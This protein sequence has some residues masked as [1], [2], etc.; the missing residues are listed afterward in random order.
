MTD[1]IKPLDEKGESFIKD[2]YHFKEML[3]GVE[4]EE[5]DIIGSLDIVGMFPNIPVKKTLEVVKEG[6]INDE[7]L[8][9][10]TEWKPE[11]ISKL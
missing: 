9:L 2:M 6:L 10:R 5:G 7:T 4:I 11:D 1:I 3:A 8:G